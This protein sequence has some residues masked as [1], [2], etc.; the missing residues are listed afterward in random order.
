[1]RFGFS[2]MSR[3]TSLDGGLKESGPLMSLP[4]RLSTVRVEGRDVPLMLPDSPSPGR[5]LRQRGRAL[6][7]CRGPGTAAGWHRGQST[8][9]APVW[10]PTGWPYH[11]HS[12][13]GIARAAIWPQDKPAASSQHSQCRV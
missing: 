8:P 7:A 12:S 2:D 6:Q 3:V 13:Q 11:Q 1:M 5:L 4:L 10:Q 9:A